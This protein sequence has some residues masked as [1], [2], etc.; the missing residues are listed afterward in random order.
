MGTFGLC[1]YLNKKGINT[2]ILNL[3]LYD[4]N[5]AGGKLDHYIRLFNPSHAGLIFHWQETAEGFLQAGE[6]IKSRFPHIKILC[7]GFT[8]GYFGENLLKRCTFP[9]FVV[10]GDPEKPLELLLGGKSLQE[11]PNLVYRDEKGIRANEVSYFIDEDT[12]SGMSFC[13]VTLLFDHELYIKAVEDKF[14]FPIFIGRGCVFQCSYCGGSCNSYRLHSERAK[15]VTRSIRSVITDL[16]RLK[17]ITRK[18]Y[19]CYENDKRYLKALF[20]E[21]KKEEGLVKAFVLNYGAWHTIDRE[22]LDLYRDVFIVDKENKPLFEISPEVFDDKSRKKVKGR[23]N[24][25]TLNDLKENLSLIN[26]RLQN[27]VN[28]SVF[29]SRYHDTA[30]TYR[31]I[32]KEIS[33]IFLLKHELLDHRITN[34]TIACDHLS[35][36]VASRY[37][38]TYVKNNRDLIHS[39]PL[40]E[41]SSHR[42]CTA[43]PLITSAYIFL[44]PCQ[45][46]IS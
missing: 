41:R 21:I 30:L 36:D 9:D 23:K 45:K 35:T 18:I 31:D 22:F 38:E 6:L 13:D 27:N 16:K 24:V 7:G 37:W 12:L 3:A 42:N 44:K 46:R 25:Y 11:I 19:I 5:E 1:D 15:P 14:G 33:G 17:G 43:F 26:D 40:Q 39:Y 34:V 4:R 10:K 28:V 2:K 8:A 32:R 20:E 29:F